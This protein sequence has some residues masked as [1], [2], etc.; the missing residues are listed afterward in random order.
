M[1]LD[2]YAFAAES[3]T[4]EGTEIAYWRKHNR[5]QGWMD[6]LWHAKG[7]VT[8]EKTKAQWGTSFNG[9]RLD[10]TAADIAELERAV[11]GQ[12]LPA[13]GGFFFGSD[14]Y[15]DMNEN[16]HYYDYEKDV[17]FI[18]EA[19][20]WLAKGRKVYYVCSW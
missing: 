11:T 2:M 8:D 17:A 10:L 12:T 9:Q 5:L 6:A 20:A 1:G 7:N 13:T 16:G 15:G 14:S 3:D 19:K 18:K 4:D